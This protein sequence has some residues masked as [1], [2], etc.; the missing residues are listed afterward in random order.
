MTNFIPMIEALRSQ[1][2]NLPAVRRLGHVTV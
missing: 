1:V 2:R